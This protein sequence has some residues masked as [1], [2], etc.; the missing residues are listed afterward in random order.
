M[1]KTLVDNERSMLNGAML[2]KKLWE[3]VVDTA[4]YLVNRS[5]SSEL[6]N[7]TPHGGI[8]RVKYI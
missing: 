3:K 5:P 1:N 2:A 7:S 8:Y 6:V 4:K